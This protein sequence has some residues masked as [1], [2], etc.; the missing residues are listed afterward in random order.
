MLPQIAN[1]IN[2][3]MAKVGTIKWHEEQIALIRSRHSKAAKK[4]H[5][6]RGNKVKP[7]N[8]PHKTKLP[9]KRYRSRVDYDFL[10]YIRVVMRWAKENNPT[11]SS[12]DIEFLLYLYGEGAFSR[13]TFRDFHKLLGLYSIKTF[14]K[15]EEEGWIKMWRPRK[16]NQHALYTLTHKAKVMCSQMHKFACGLEEM[17]TSERSNRMARKD[18][19][20]P[21]MNSYYLE[22][23]KK[24]NKDRT[25]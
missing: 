5:A 6:T 17:P 18:E 12:G 2:Y 10:K 16:G 19:E 20:N 11:L 13:K 1:I 15:Y 4:A 9:P 25:T 21:R 7:D 24:M 22:I 23:I 3:S 14:K 8:Y